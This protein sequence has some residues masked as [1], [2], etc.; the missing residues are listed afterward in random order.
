MA[1]GDGRMAEEGPWEV[2]YWFRVVMAVSTGLGE[3]DMVGEGLG[4]EM[5]IEMDDE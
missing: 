5:E 4:M 2:R 1:D 3:L